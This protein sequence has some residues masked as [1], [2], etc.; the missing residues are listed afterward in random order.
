[1][2]KISL[3]AKLYYDDLGA[4]TPTHELTNVRDLSVPDEMGEADISTRG[5]EFELTAVT[6]EKLSIE[7]QM[8]WNESDTGF[9]AILAAYTGNTGIALM[10]LSSDDGAGCK[11][12]FDILKCSKTENLKDG[13]LADV[14]AKPRGALTPVA[15]A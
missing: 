11:G 3:D 7:W 13:V 14:V 12:D 15:A 5:S 8:N 6:M 2:S 1:M 9:L 10:C 4:V